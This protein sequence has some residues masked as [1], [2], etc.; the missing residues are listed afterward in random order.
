MRNAILFMFHGLLLAFLTAGI[1]HAGTKCE[2]KGP[3]KLG[4]TTATL[5][6]VGTITSDDVKGVKRCIESSKSTLGI[7]RVELNSVGGD[8]DAA[9]DIVDLLYDYSW[10]SPVVKG[11]LAPSV[12]LPMS[13]KGVCAS[14]CV[15]IFAGARFRGDWGGTP[16][17]V[18]KTSLIVHS[19]FTTNTSS[20]FEDVAGAFRAMK[21]RA[22][23]QFER[24]GVSA[25]LWDRMTN[26]PSERGEIL[27]YEEASNFGLTHPDPAYTDYTNSLDAKKLG[28]S[29]QEYLRRL[30]VHDT[31]FHRI[32]DYDLCQK[33][34]G[35]K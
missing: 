12:G 21:S 8:V 26:V 23:K 18:L 28:V 32:L 34:A 22:I 9:Q 10:Y 31:C 30:A 5:S 19:P 3:N 13:G 14:A 2:I 15:F 16:Q 6:I 33:K 27:T 29:K 1:S 11:N 25:A 24:V 35:L 7:N 4:Y 20:S 17:N